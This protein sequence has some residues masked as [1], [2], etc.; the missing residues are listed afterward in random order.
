MF[1]W[2]GKVSFVPYS[3]VGEFA[4][5]LKGGRLMGS[6]CT[7]CGYATFP[8]RADCSRCLSGEFSFREW[9]GRGTVYTFTTITAAPTGFE[10][11]GTYTVAV[12]ARE[13]TDRLLDA[14][15]R[16]H[17]K[18]RAAV[19]TPKLMLALPFLQQLCPDL[20]LVHVLRDGRDVAS[21]TSRCGWRRL[22]TGE[23]TVR[24][25]YASALRRWVSWIE[26]FEADCRRLAIQ[27]YCCRFEQLVRAPADEMRGVLGHLGIRWSE[28]VLSPHHHPHDVDPRRREGISAFHRRSGID[29]SRAFRWQR[30]LT[31]AQRR[32]TLR[33]AEA[34]LHRLGYPP[35][36]GAR[37]G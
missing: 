23:G 9:S 31:W 37:G 15:A 5:H 16:A 8:P 13:F 10:D 7:K 21:S 19:K 14:A 34:T 4:V 35:T 22:W 28:A 2:F 32:V 25:G 17:G 18:T 26:R 11:L 6:V 3:K 1:S 33:L 24:N 29:A 12:A 30:E 36:S 27:P 20:R